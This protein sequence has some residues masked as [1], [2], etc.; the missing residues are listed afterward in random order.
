MNDDDVLIVGGVLVLAY[1]LWPKGSTS[2]TTIIQGAPQASS[3]ASCDSCGGATPPPAGTSPMPSPAQSFCTGGQILRAGVCINPASDAPRIGSANNDAILAE[4]TRQLE[5]S[6][7]A[8]NWAL[9]W[10]IAARRD[11]WIKQQGY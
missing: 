4:I 8:G 11:A 3:G 7:A 9:S 5:A 10:E 1:L 6:N 2:T